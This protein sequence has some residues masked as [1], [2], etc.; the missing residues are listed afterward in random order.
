MRTVSLLLLVAFISLAESH[1]EGHKKRAK[2]ELLARSK[3]RWVLSTIEVV[4]EDP[5]PYPK[6]ISQMHNDQ[7]RENGHKFRLSGMGVTENPLGVFAIDE[8]TGTVYAL[9]PIDREEC[10][11]FHIKFDILDKQTGRNIDRD[12]AIDVEIKDIND[13]AP[14]FSYPR[15]NAS[16][17]ENTPEG[18]LPVQLQVTDRDKR[19]TPNSTVTISIISQNPQE[20]KIDVHQIDQRMAQLT[21]KGCFNYDK[22]NKYE[23]VVQAKDHGTPSLSST[24]VVTLNILDTNSHPPTF[25]DNKYQSE[26]LEAVTKHNVLRV[27]VDDKDTPK[28]PGWRAKYFFI[29]GNEEEHFKIETDP[30]TNEGIL[31]V[32]KGQDFEKTSFTTLQI[33]VQ[34]E[35]PLFICKNESP[36]SRSALPP[37]HSVSVT[38]KVIDANDPPEFEKGTVHIHQK[39]EEPPGKLLFTPNV[40]DADSNVSHIR[41]VLLEDRANWVAVDKT[42]GK[43]TT[44]KKMDRESPFV[45][46]SV[47]KIVISAIDDGEPPATGTCTI[48]VHLRDINDNTPKLVNSS[49]IMC[50]NKV[51]KVM[52]PAKDLD[53]PPFSGPFIFSLGGD[54][55][56]VKQ[57]W[58]LDPATG[59]EGGLVSV[60][61]LPYGKYSVP[62]VI[63]DQ[64]NMA[65]HDTLEV[66]V[67]ECGEVNVCRSKKP[68]SSSLGAPGI[69]LI[70]AGLLLFLLLLLI[71]AC[72]C[73]KK[74]LPMVQ[75]EG[76]QTLIKYNQEGGGSACTAEP[77]LLQTPTNDV[78]VTDG[79]IQATVQM[80]QMPPLMTQEMN[81]YSS[82]GLSMMSSHMTSLGVQPPR[83]SLRSHEGQTMYSTQT[84]NRMNTYQGRSPRYHDSLGLWA[85]Q[86]IADHINRKFNMIDGDQVDYPVYRPYKYAYEG[87]GSKC[88]SLD[89]L[90]LSNLGDDLK[91]LNDLG[92]K[93]KTLGGICH[94]AIQEK[95]IQL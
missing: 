34:N 28:T 17:K 48:L 95:N 26:V 73:G 83:G 76:N 70:F 42:T 84:A 68:I 87:Q 58:K 74:E 37:P 43:I 78:A 79:L 41:Y 61:M 62:L 67:C 82:S 21:V 59:Q 55:K 80:S 11:L 38:V 51:N 9:K 12:L 92:P 8:D 40:K 27:A 63:A 7:A 5:G 6:I 57:R 90:S 22:V 39:E 25:R 4:E 2:R 72:Q 29:K 64:Q 66:M 46:N 10:D 20:P 71:F 77:I 69:G 24:T 88:Q 13:N 91:F 53:L 56:N 45:N 54:D 65:G 52:V 49:V 85:N 35:E 75:D 33:G 1:G 18:Y 93:F 19:D 30:E 50:E 60:T 89:E 44:T 3:R 23:V 32:I 81:M 31:S 36:L 94:Q 16:V 14:T 86:H 47:Y 15:M